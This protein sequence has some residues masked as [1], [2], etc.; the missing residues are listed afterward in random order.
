MRRDDA[1][2]ILQSHADLL[3]REGVVHVS[4]FGSVARDAASANSD[5]DLIVETAPGRPITLFNIGPLHDLLARL[6]G[7]PVDVIDK[8][9]FDRAERLRRRAGDLVHVF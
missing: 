9:G 8:A 1:I 5:V 4:L 7:T 6:L 3:R 2:R